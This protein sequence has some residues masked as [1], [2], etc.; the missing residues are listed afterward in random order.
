MPFLLTESSKSLLLVLLK[1]DPLV[2]I[3]VVQ[4][5]N[6][7][8]AQALTL[9]GSTRLRYPPRS[10]PTCDHYGKVGHIRPNFFQ[11]VGYPPNWGQQLQNKASGKRGQFKPVGGY[12]GPKYV[13][14]SSRAHSAGLVAGLGQ[15]V[16]SVQFAS[17]SR[18]RPT[19]I[20]GFNPA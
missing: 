18:T 5:G 11:P 14:N 17:A 15:Q 2:T 6:S 19:S 10:Q 7:S 9:I 12:L 1:W 20:S 13:E 4:G 8:A 3:F 16:N